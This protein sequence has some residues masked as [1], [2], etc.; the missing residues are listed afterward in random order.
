MNSFVCN[1]KNKLKH[2]KCEKYPTLGRNMNA[3]YGIE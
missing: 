2:K 3:V 1:L